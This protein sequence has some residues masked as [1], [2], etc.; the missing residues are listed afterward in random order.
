MPLP[1]EKPD[2]PKPPHGKPGPGHLKPPPPKKHG[3]IWK[4]LVSSIVIS[5]I[6][7]AILTT[8]LL[9]LGIP[10]NVII[11]SM[12]TIFVGIPAIVLA[13]KHK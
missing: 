11:P 6:V 4:R 13:V 3:N 5:A 9:L 2:G 10:I 8:A 12:A 1:H 7:T